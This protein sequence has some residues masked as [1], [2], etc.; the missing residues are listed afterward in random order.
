MVTQILFTNALNFFSTV[1]GSG[2]STGGSTGSTGS[3]GTTGSTHTSVSVGSA[4]SSGATAHAHIKSARL[5]KWKGR[6]YLELL[7]DGP[8]AQA[9]LRL[10][11]LAKNGKLIRQ[12]MLVVETGTTQTVRIPFS[13]AVHTIRLAVV[14]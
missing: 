5:I 4:A 2:G 6:H 12:T 9:H 14:S 8:N 11:E 7:V 13:G 3:I 1:G 10:S